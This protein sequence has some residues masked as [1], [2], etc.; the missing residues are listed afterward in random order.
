MAYGT[1]KRRSRSYSSSRGSSRRG[2]YSGSY[3]RAPR[4]R[5]RSSR[6]SSGGSRTIR[7]VVQ[8]VPGGV[9]GAPV[10]GSASAVPL[11]AMF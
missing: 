3:R 1:R 8:T 10:S 5:A 2:S 4:K 9:Q 11:R 7:I 6:R